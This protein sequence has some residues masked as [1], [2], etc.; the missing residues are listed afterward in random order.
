MNNYRIWITYHRDE[1]VEQY[2]LR[3]DET[4]K[5]FAAHKE[6]DGDN[7]NIMNPVFSEMV[8]MYYVWKNQKKSNFVGFNH[9]RR[10]FDVTRLPKRGECQIYTTYDFG[11]KTVYQ[12]YAKC[13]N[14]EDMDIML[15]ILD[16]QYGADNTYSKYIR[17]SHTLIVNC[18]FLMS[19]ANFDKLCKFLF[20]LIEEFSKHLG[21]STVEGWRMKAVNDFGEKKADYQMRVVSF[22]AERLIAAWIFTNMKTYEQ[23]DVVIVNY[24]TQELTDAAIMSL[25][26][27]TPGCSVHVFDNS[28]KEPFVNKHKNVDVIDNTEGQVIDFDMFLAGFPDKEETTKNNFASAKHTYTV[29]KCFELFPNGF[30]LM[31]SDI[32]IKKD[33]GMF[34]DKRKAFVG[35]EFCNPQ[36]RLQSVPRVLPFLCY[37]NV[38]TCRLNGVSYFDGNRTWKLQKGPDNIYDTGASFLEDCKNGGLP[39]LNVDIF[40]YC[41]HLGHGSWHDNECEKWIEANKE[42]WQ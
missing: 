25:N 16:K 27:H 3:E 22:L 36:K 29:E 38:P 31:D 23:R 32:L 21:I 19:W 8:T 1:Q 34:F 2:G 17:E 7:I 33:V 24:N 30:L 39:F 41:I 42:L 13:H 18:C 37:I 10:Q 9:Y 28:D 40:E 4:H 20:S 12:Q 14:A 11:G 15:S 5:L 35:Q 26:K 6:A